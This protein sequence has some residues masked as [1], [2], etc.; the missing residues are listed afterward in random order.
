[1]WKFF[2]KLDVALVLLILMLLALSSLTI[3]SFIGTYGKVISYWLFFKHIISSL[4]AVSV[5]L[6]LA[7]LDY[8]LIKSSVKIF[9]FLTV[10]L[11]CLVLLLGATIKGASSWFLLGGFAFQPTELAK[12][13]SILVLAKY[14]EKYHRDLYTLKYIFYSVVPVGLIVGLVLLQPDFGSAMIILSV[15]VAMILLSGIQWKHFLV[16]LLTGVMVSL[17]L[18]QFVFKDYQ[19]DRILTFLSPYE[20]PLGRGYNTVQA[21][22]AVKNGGIFG[23]GLGSAEQISYLPEIQTDFIF[24]G[25]SQA[26][27]FVGVSVYFVI[28]LGILWRLMVIAKQTNDYFSK[29]LVFG[30]GS[31]FFIQIAINVGMNLGLLPITG[32]PLPFMSYGGSSMLIFGIIF[33]LVLSVAKHKSSSINKN[34]EGSTVVVW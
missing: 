19:K 6:I 25:F 15:W 4:I 5:M 24:A 33:G 2:E 26:W 18:W 1:M 14:L 28:I 10:G 11:L 7:N 27:G 8:R 29:V 17:G 34:W 13:I 20:D 31:V 21:L 32:I 3:F 9:Y 12:I 16:F 22:E 23:T 30:A